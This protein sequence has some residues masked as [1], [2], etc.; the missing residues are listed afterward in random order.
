MN[1]DN[2]AGVEFSN[3]EMY[4]RNGR[5]KVRKMP[6]NAYVAFVIFILITIAPFFLLISGIVDFGAEYIFMQL[7]IMVA[8]I[9]IFKISPYTQSSKSYYIEFS[10]EN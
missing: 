10:N 4:L 7:L 9:F 1:S 3:G 6:A 2:I 5:M 8:V